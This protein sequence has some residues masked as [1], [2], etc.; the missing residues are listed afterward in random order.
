MKQTFL[1]F[2]LT[3][4]LLSFAQITEKKIVKNKVQFKTVQKGWVTMSSDANHF[5]SEPEL[6]PF[7]ENQALF[8][9]TY[10]KQSTFDEGDRIAKTDIMVYDA[11]TNMQYNL[12]SGC[13]SSLSGGSNVTYKNTTTF[14]VACL[15]NISNIYPSKNGVFFESSAW[16]TDNAVHYYDANTKQI[17]FIHHGSIV[18]EVLSMEQIVIEYSYKTA[19]G[20][21]TK[22]EIFGNSLD[23]DNEETE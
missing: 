17:Y 10:L 18:D 2:L 19:S 9:R 20:R 16:A 23:I 7:N 11:R 3:I 1:F 14:P 12:V 5:E 8:L 13:G 6:Y 21:E 22:R 15:Y 4:C